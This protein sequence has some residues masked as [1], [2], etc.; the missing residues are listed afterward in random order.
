MDALILSPG[1]ALF[2]VDV[3]NDFLPGGSLEVPDGDQVIPPLNQ[4]LFLFGEANLPIF[5]SRDWHPADHS[6]FI[7]QGG[8]WPPHCV[9][10]TRGASFA[11]KLDIPCSIR[12]IS[13]ATSIEEDAY[14]AFDK[15]NLHLELQSLRIGRL[16]IGGLATD[17]CIKATVLDGLRLGYEIFVLEDAIRAVN[18]H[19]DDGDKAILE[20]QEAGAHCIIAKQLQLNPR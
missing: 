6:S 1:D 10:H 9:Q 20:M 16:I 11:N 5:A 17:Y 19:P 2:I 3:Q 8:T 12:I 18:G 4:A 14:S 13:K 7:E 15:T